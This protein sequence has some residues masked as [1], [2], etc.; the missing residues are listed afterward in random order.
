MLCMASRTKQL[1][2]N[3]IRAQQRCGVRVFVVKPRRRCSGLWALKGEQPLV[4]GR[5][6][7]LWAEEPE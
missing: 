6:H 3:A 5:L 1:R 2:P 4:E 7:A